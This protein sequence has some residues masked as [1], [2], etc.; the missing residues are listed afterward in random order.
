[1]MRGVC[2]WVLS[3]GLWFGPPVAADTAAVEPIARA[4]E[5]LEQAGLTLMEADTTQDRIAALTRAVR[6]YEAGLSALRDGARQAAL[7]EQII[8]TLF[9][10]ERTRL[11]RLLGAMQTIQTNQS[12]LILL[13]PHGP[14]GAAQAGMVVGDITPAIAQE[15]L[16]LQ[17]QLEDLN[18]MR[19]LQVQALEELSTALIAAQNARLALS[20]AIADRVTPPE[21]FTFDQNTLRE[22]VENAA[23]LDNLATEL[24]ATSPVELGALPSFEAA[25]GN[26]QMPVL[27]TILR[28][29]NDTDAAGI[30]RPGVVIAT[31]PAALVTAPWPAFVRYAGPLLDHGNVIILEPDDRY[32]I[33]L[34]GLGD[35]YV[36]AGQLVAADAPIALMPGTVGAREELIVSPAQGSGAAG[37]ETLY[38]EL[39]QDSRPIDPESWFALRQ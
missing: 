39:R 15:A 24:A 32:L 4:A 33:V 10:T 16:M 25:A 9:E 22:L 26:L 5:L 3:V 8:L 29:F 13:H 6:A 34:T 36:T 18:A 28:R 38:L 27:G 7:R 21:R 31:P 20:Q 1:M 23:S 14:L 35:L 12:P 11:A 17:A 30:R 2:A 37:I 19:D